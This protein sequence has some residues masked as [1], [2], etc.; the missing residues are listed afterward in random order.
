M[1]ILKQ[2]VV[3]ERQR[4]AD[5]EKELKKYKEAKENIEKS[6]NEKENSIILLSKEKYELQSK[7]DIEKT[8]LEA[9]NNNNN[10]SSFMSLFRRPSVS[11]SN[12]QNEEVKRLLNENVE[13]K[14]ELEGMK[15]KYEENNQDFEKCKNEYQI[16]INL[17][18]EKIKKFDIVI[19]EKN[20]QYDEVNRKLSQMYENWKAIDI[21][22]V[23]LENKYFDL[24]KENKQK[25]EK[26]IQLDTLLEEKYLYNNIRVKKIEFYEESIKR[27]AK[28]SAELANK[29]A[30]LKNAII[31]NNM[32]VHNF[33]GEKIG[34]F[35]NTSIEVG[36]FIK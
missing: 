31:D 34:L 32:V 6:L 30:E 15:F 5:L 27:Q 2:G 21:E 17:Q 11:K 29:L 9:A 25:D 13:L 22:R 35:F 28:E 26:I 14:K 24:Q 18:L 8:K 20:A 7:L 36:I 4:N 3:N 12:N 23:K 19:A 33:K 1:N 16:I 10:E